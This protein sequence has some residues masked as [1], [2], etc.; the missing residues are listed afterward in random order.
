VAG[1]KFLVIPSVFIIHVD[2]GEPKWRGKGDAVR[3]YKIL[4]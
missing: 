1:Y 4:E 2:H 3:K